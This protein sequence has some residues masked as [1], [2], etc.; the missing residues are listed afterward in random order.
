MLTYRAL[1]LQIS[2]LQEGA[3][4][5]ATP[6]GDLSTEK[7]DEAELSVP[8]SA[9]RRMTKVEKLVGASIQDRVFGTDLVKYMQQ[10]PKYPIPLVAEQSILYLNAHGETIFL[11]SPL[12]LPSRI[13]PLL[14][15]FFRAAKT[16]GLFGKA[17]VNAEEIDCS[18]NPLTKVSES[19][20]FLKSNF[21]FP[22]EG[23]DVDLWHISNPHVVAALLKVYLRELPNPLLCNCEYI[24]S[25]L[26]N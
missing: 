17:P 2:Y 12:P 18:R 6:D 7:E 9:P 26:S 13:H 19:T 16:L 5:N 4:E 23:H 1:F 10:H 11:P 22:H 25:F 8:V 14:P 3:N 24:V 15:L 21:F 20:F